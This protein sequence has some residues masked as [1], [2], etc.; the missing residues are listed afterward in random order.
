MKNIYNITFYMLA[1]SFLGACGK[2][3]LDVEPKGTQLESNY[4][5][6]A[7][8][9]FLG[10]VAA[11]DPMGWE[12]VD[13]YGNFVS[14]NAASDD[15]Y[16]GGGSS[17]DVPYIN[18][19]N[20]Y[21]LTPALGPQQDFW[22]KGYTGVTRANTIL[23]KLENP[24]PDLSEELKNRYVAE[25]KF[26][27][28]YY[29]FELVRLFC[30]IPLITEQLSTNEIY[31]ISQAPP[32]D[33]YNQIEAD[34]EDAVAEGEL[35]DIVTG[36]ERGRVSK[37]MA[38]ALLGKVYLYQEKW[39]EAIEQLEEVNGTPGGTSQYGY[40]LLDDFSEIFKPDNKYHT[41]AILEISHTSVAA[42]NNDPKSELEGL[43][44]S[45]MLGPR[46]Y[47][48]TTYYSG[49]GACPITPE[50]F[51]ALHYDPR[52]TTTIA[53]MDSL[54]DLGE[55]TYVPGYQNTGYFVQKFAPLVE[56]QSTGGGK[57]NQ[58]YPQNY[59]EI[60]LADTY[61]MEAEALIE[62]GG[63]TNRAGELLNSVRARVGLSSVSPTLENIYYERR[64]E[65]ATE[66]HRWYDLVRTG[67]AKD[68]LSANGFVENKNE[69]LPIPIAELA[70]TLLEQ[71]P[72]Y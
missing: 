62:S 66:G 12:G 2:S 61:L 71:N 14:L 8:E 39:E 4:Y 23:T 60:R 18:S 7:P 53:D 52:Y 69:I 44:A 5:K 50:L 70:N 20:N 58:N 11:Y 10:L 56:Y 67:Q 72:N 34:L 6:D 1:I 57:M 21:T 25:A 43:M 35:P 45:L 9:V 24:V 47:S 38:K 68:V 19:M 30:N 54:V 63:D 40:R 51:D 32:E 3:F 13:S 15:C 17:S 26:L 46:S 36:R 31:D 37:G 29:Y 22:D 65:L 49:W 28:A 16:G 64:L 48:G 33:V 59:I 55:A 42:K 27:R 41:E